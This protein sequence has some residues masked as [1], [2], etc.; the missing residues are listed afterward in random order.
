M[1]GW[2]VTFLVIALIAALFGFS[3]LAGAA[4]GIAKLLFFL[5]LVMF[6]IILILGLV[7]PIRSI[8]FLFPEF[9]A[10]YRAPFLTPTA[11]EYP[12]GPLIEVSADAEF[13][14]Q[15]HA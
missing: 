15:W 5:F 8:N 13:P 3:G 11:A 4:M 1:L 14:L 10:A 9:P 12:P 7:L 2:A 6:V